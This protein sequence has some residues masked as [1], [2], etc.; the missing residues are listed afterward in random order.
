MA[1]G[2]S[3]SSKYYTTSFYEELRNGSMRSAEIILPLVLDITH[4]RSV[5]DVGCGDGSWLAVC[6][7]LGVEEILGID[8]D[9]IDRE[10]LQIP[11]EHFQAADLTKPIGVGRVFDLV[12]S[13][14]VAEHLP[15]SS[16]SVFVESL[17]GLG[18][19]VLFS[20]AIPLQGGN[21][22]IN[23][24][25]L[26]KWAVLF[27]EH[28][29]LPVDCIRKHVWQNDAVEWWYAQ[30]MLLFARAPLLN[31]N[32]VLKTAFDQTNP[33]QLRLVHPRNYLEA[34]IPVQ[35]PPWN[36]RT[37]LQLLIDCFRSAIMRRLYSILGKDIPS[38]KATNLP[39]FNA[40]LQNGAYIGLT[41]RSGPNVK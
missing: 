35:A 5:V 41:K 9:Y 16:S 27:R 31:S 3:V 29:Y 32:T 26:D 18:P 25:W 22:H 34:F 21:H 30:N 14:E 7:K 40:V 24:Q 12:I 33:T 8:G 38:R 10:I 13:L 37:A 2:E 11:Q 36:V 15:A 19:L 4:P 20:A 39:N 17:T 23:E 28:D 6:R 1:I